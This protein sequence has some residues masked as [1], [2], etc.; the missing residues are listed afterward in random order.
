[1]Q[2]NFQLIANQ[3]SS[4]THNTRAFLRPSHAPSRHEYDFEEEED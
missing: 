4:P 3:F 1:M 2:A